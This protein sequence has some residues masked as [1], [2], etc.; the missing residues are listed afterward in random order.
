MTD[1]IVFNE[2][3]QIT[4]KRYPDKYF[5]YVIDDV[6]YGINL[7]KMAFLTEKKHTIKQKNKTRLSPSKN[8]KSYTVKQWDNCTPTQEYFDEMRRISHHQI[9]FGVEYVDWEGLGTGRIKWNKGVDERM[10]FKSYEMAYCSSINYEHQVDLLWNG[11]RQAENLE[12]PMRQ[13]GNKK[14]N[15]KRIHPC[16]KPILLYK[17]I[18][19][20]FDLKDKKVYCGHNGSG[21]DRIALDEYV[22]EFVASE[23]DKEY[24]DL[25]ENRWRNYKSQPKLIF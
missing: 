8:N 23:I 14:L 18:A 17:K 10:S 9:I 13:Q 15:E 6:P 5:D 1:S 21:S 25:Q 7:G 3:W 2:P 16:H 20:D 11:M 22:K 19:L 4:T 12:N 24:F